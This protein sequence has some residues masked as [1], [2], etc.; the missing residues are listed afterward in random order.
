MVRRRMLFP[1]LLPAATFAFHLNVSSVFRSLV[2]LF[3]SSSSF[4][5]ILHGITS[6]DDGI[7]ESK[8]RSFEF[9]EI[10]KDVVDLLSSTVLQL[11]RFQAVQPSPLSSIDSPA[12][13]RST[14]EVTPLNRSVQIQSRV[15]WILS[16]SSSSLSS[17]FVR[18]LS[19]LGFGT[20]TGTA[21]RMACQ[22]SSTYPTLSCDS[23]RC[24]EVQSNMP[25]ERKSSIKS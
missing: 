2:L 4:T 12:V 25:D 8:T 1:P 6:G 15:Q 18:G 14:P 9:V 10:L 16:S 7:P 17:S 3:L 11:P 20:S 5:F 24:R 19:N 13:G 21:T 23:A 22:V